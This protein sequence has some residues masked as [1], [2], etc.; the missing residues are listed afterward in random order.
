MARWNENEFIKHAQSIAQQHLVTK[1]SLNELSEK[2]A[3][4]NS[5][6]PE[7]IRTLVRLAN[8]ATFQELFKNKNDGD[9]MV[10]FETG[11]PEA[12]IR[13]MVS[14]SSEAPQSANIGNDKLAGELPDLMKDKRRG[15]S[16][17]NPEPEKVAA[18]ADAVK[19]A[20][21]D[22]VVMSLRKLSSEFSIEK[23]AAGARWEEELG[24]LVTSFKRAPGYGPEFSSFEKEAWA[25]FGS[26][27]APEMAFLYEELR[28]NKAPPASEKVA[29]LMERVA[30]SDTKE[31]GILKEAVEARKTFQKMSGALAWIDKNMPAL[32]R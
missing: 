5:L 13:R 18:D 22:V 19:P 23:L 6:N 20:R 29:L 11:D 25:S 7:E 3:S 9:K 32:G 26:D 31:L 8:V 27:V 21:T 30:V 24:K 1:K 16:L 17:A 10:E 15:F 28:L 4:E 12:V 2:F 14:A